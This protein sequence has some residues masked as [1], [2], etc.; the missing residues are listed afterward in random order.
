MLNVTRQ[1]L[2]ARQRLPAA[3]SLAAASLAADSQNHGE[4]VAHATRACAVAVPLLG[5]ATAA[6]ALSLAVS[7]A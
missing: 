7:P 4:A 3:A 5:A 6:V 2:R 1:R